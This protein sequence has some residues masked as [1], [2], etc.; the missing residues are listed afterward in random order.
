MKE[1]KL[2]GKEYIPQILENKNNSSREAGI[3]FLNL[4][5]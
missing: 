1:S 2:S 4:P 3:C 5:I